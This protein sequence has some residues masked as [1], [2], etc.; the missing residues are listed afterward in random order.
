MLQPAA[1]HI[2]VEGKDMNGSRDAE[3]LRR[4]IGIV[5]EN[6]DNQFITTSVERE[7]AFG[8]ENLGVEPDRIRERVADTIE[9]FSLQ[10][11]RQRAP[12]TLS[13]GE[14][15]RV[16]I[17]A[18]LIARPRYLILDEPTVFLDPVSRD[19][20]RGIVCAL[21]GEI[22]IIFISQFPSEILLADKIYELQR[23]HLKGPIGKESMF[24]LYREYDSTIRFL[25]KL[26]KRGILDGNGIPPVD[27]LC[28]KL[29]V[30]KE[31]A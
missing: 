28:A 10:S 23:G 31:S 21:K 6:P 11:I 24:E 26:K 29:D 15:Q 22:T 18:T 14:K 1:G 19:M 17:A 8:L 13:G 5:F 25:H 7:L 3:K 4:Q 27:E 9:R 2:M 20:V 30:R 16:A 12:H